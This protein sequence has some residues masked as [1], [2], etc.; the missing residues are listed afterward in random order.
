MPVG[1]QVIN[2]DNIVQIDQDYFNYSL[3]RTGSVSL[4]TSFGPVSTLF[5]NG[6]PNYTGSAPIIAFRSSDNPVSFYRAIVTGNTYSYF[7]LGPFGVEVQYWIFDKVE[8][9]NY[10]LDSF[11]LEV[12]NSLGDVVY[13]SSVPVIR[14]SGVQSSDSNPVTYPSGKSYAVLQSA[15]VWNTE[16]TIAEFGEF[17]YRYRSTVMAPTFI[18]DNILG[19]TLVTVE[20]YYTDLGSEVSSFSPPC[21][22]VLIDITNLTFA[23]G[24]DRFTT[25]NQTMQPFTLS[26]QVSN[27]APGARTLDLVQ[28]MQPFTLSSSV[29]NVAPASR[30]VSLTQ[31]MQPFTLI[32][33]VS[34]TPPGERTLSLN[35]TLQP[36]TLSSSVNNSDLT[37]DP[38]DWNNIN[39]IGTGFNAAQ[40]ISGISQSITLQ[41]SWTGTI[42][43]VA[44]VY[45]DGDFGG[46][47]SNGGTFVVNNNQTVS[48]TVSS[49][50]EISS[51]TATVTNQST[52]T[53]LDT[54]TFNV[55]PEFGGGF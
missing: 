20:D 19:S 54:F 49:S 50:L 17:T 41:F 51:G 39:G 43:G 33:E 18:T 27:T 24:S 10:T 46:D 44:T 6:T 47:L 7:F 55:D 3:V 11:G 53:V 34:N 13:H 38:V 14:V 52:N 35:Q 30:T 42:T 15:L 9:T 28:T 4:T 48:F 36:F 25:L 32:S 22:F 12:R 5:Y 37:P 16:Q 21:Q 1:L 40:T 31:T 8:F 23:T 29:G 45:I 26:S 2:D